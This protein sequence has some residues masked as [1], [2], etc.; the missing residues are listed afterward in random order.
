MEL[1]PY[2]AELRES[3]LAAASLGDENTQRSTAALGA[4]L[5]PAARLALLHALSD[6]AAEVTAQLA[7]TSPVDADTILVDVRLDGRDVR[8]ATTRS[9]SQDSASAPSGAAPTGDSADT[10]GPVAD[11]PPRS[12]A[13]ASGDFTRTTVRMFNELKGQAEKA[14][15]E[16]GVSLNSFISRAVSE[17]IRGEKGERGRR[18]GRHGAPWQQHS[19]DWPNGRGDSISG[20]VQG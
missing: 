2:V 17:A 20:Y 8:I 10:G 14:A 9:W 3:L 4:A 16:Q 1:T 7:Q 19:R 18:G 15:S 13:D 11:D 6:M 12:F 5:E